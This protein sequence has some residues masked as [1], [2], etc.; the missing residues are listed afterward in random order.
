MLLGVVEAG[1]QVSERLAAPVA[2][3]AVD[4]GLAVAGRA[5]GIDHDDHVAVGGKKFG[6]PAIGPGVAPVALRTAVDQEFDGIFLGGIEGWGLDEEA[7]ELGF[8]GGG[9][10][11]VLHLGQ[12]ELD[13]K[14]V[15]EVSD[16]VRL[17]AICGQAGQRIFLIARMKAPVPGYGDDDCFRRTANL[18]PCGKN[19]N[20]NTLD[21]N[22]PG[23]RCACYY[24]EIAELR[25]TGDLLF[26]AAVQRLR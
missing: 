5:A 2:V 25:A 8:V 20:W 17:V 16:E 26:Y 21:V 13:E 1:H 11:E 4:D 9:E 18:H 12:V 22:G 10:P 3:H 15:V 6:V 23:R 14:G 19:R 24:M 7:L